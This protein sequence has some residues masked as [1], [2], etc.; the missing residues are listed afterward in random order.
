MAAGHVDGQ[1]G[2][3][4][5]RQTGDRDRF[6]DDFHSLL[7]AVQARAE[8][9]LVSD[10]HALKSTARQRR[11]QGAVDGDGHLQRLGVGAGA[12]RQQE[13]VLEVEVAAGVEAAADEVDHRQ[14]QTGLIVGVQPAPQRQPLRRGGGAGH[15][16]RHAEHGVGAGPRLVRRTVDLTQNAID[17]GLVRR[18]HA[19]QSRSQQVADVGDR[20]AD[21]LAAVSG[22]IAVAQLDGLM[23]A[24]AGPGRH[25][26]PA[27]R[28]VA[29][30]HL[31]LDGRPAA[32]VEYFAGV[33][34]H[35]RGVGLAHA[36]ASKGRN[37]V[38]ASLNASSHEAGHS[39]SRPRPSRRTASRRVSSGRYS[40]GLVPS[41]RASRQRPQ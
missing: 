22:G 10:Q 5:R 8:T 30:G 27:A 21:A 20:L 13:E 19:D 9:A 34:A 12:D 16:H 35:D 36:D 32:A 6:Q 23:P 15:G 18:R 33:D 38:S 40:T 41:M 11:R 24:G 2:V 1:S 14:R 17:A 7:V 26:G 4:A 39:S 37:A 25:D 31:D 3:L 29:A 28:A